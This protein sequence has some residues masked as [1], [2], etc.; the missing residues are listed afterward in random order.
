MQLI[1]L[2]TT[3]KKIHLINEKFFDFTFCTLKNFNF[4]FLTNFLKKT[5][6]KKN[7][8]CTHS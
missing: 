1:F 2:A 8:Y 7:Q 6:S 3:H 5:R 4:F